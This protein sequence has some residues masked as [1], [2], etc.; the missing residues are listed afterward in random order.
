[1]LIT[2]KTVYIV[3][4]SL[5]LFFLIS[6]FI[7][8]IRKQSE[9]FKTI[10]GI[11]FST[12]LML[13]FGI[14]AVNVQNERLAS[15]FYSLLYSVLII[16]NIVILRLITILEGVPEEVK[17]HKFIRYI[18]YLFVLVDAVFIS[19]K[20]ECF[21][22]ISPSFIGDTFYV[23]NIEYKHPFIVHQVIGFSFSIHI[24]IKL[25]KNISKNHLFYRKRFTIFLIL[26]VF[27]QICNV[28]YIT[29]VSFFKLD[30]TPLI[31]GIISIYA[32]FF[33]AFTIPRTIKDNMLSIASETIS[34][35]VICFDNKGNCLYCN[36]SA[37][38]IYK[39]GESQWIN[40]YLD[41]PKDEIKCEEKIDIDGDT[42]TFNV[43]FKKI[44]DLSGKYSGAYIKLNDMTIELNEIKLEEY[45]AT[46]DEL[47]G[48]ANRAAFFN[49]CE[50]VIRQNPDVP[51]YLVATNIK[52][53]K[54]IN[55]LFGTKF[56][57]NI[58]KRQADMLD[59]ANYTNCVK[60]RV[61]GD[62]F[63]M[64]IP[65]KSF[66]IDLAVQNT[67]F[68]REL[69][70]NVRFPLTIQIG[71]YEIT[72][73]TEKVYTM[74]NKAL[75]ALKNNKDGVNGP[76]LV[77]FYDTSLMNR[78][79]YEQNIIGEFRY[80]LKNNDF[81]VFIQAQVDSATDTCKGG[82]AL[83]R[84]YDPKALYRQPGDFIEILES[85][86]L[87]YKLD[88]YVWESAAKILSKWKKAGHEDFYISVNISAKDFYYNDLYQVFTKLV[89]QYDISPANYNLELTESA[90][91]DKN[92]P[93]KNVLQRLREYGFRIEMD[94][95]G[96]GYSS[97][98]VLKE[99]K[100]DVLK[101][102]MEFLHKSENEDR[103][104]SIIL[105]IVNMAKAL[106]M[107]VIAEGVE[108]NEQKDF[109]KELG[110][111]TF[112]GYL[113]SKPIEVSEFEEKYMGGTI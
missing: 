82:E 110:V 107:K 54:F 59:K 7:E 108:T 35:A 51:R 1:M 50:K 3:I 78:I 28:I 91:I 52:N 26:Y 111:D 65:K 24:L 70:Q 53:F 92:T 80:A 37:K 13:V 109:L 43:E 67:N 71:V 8:S 77:S 113:F 30:F 101:I 74:Y 112:Q 20:P 100:M 45:R 86:G 19:V 12:I 60:G 38:M 97:L 56:G 16:T 84:W 89:E 46:H 17:S 2:L 9:L 87:I 63:A 98:N 29:N 25:I 4:C 94:D 14:Y 58:I 10:A 88:Y 99:I 34:D 11:Q 83:V 76:N 75:L 32:F 90:V 69:G 57:D 55:D 6:C 105:S 73:P 64:L 42:H 27:E 31:F 23:W 49:K 72:D 22:N 68:V 61:S 102:D 66:N 48:L 106:E 41:S 95:F 47:T 103:G 44:R 62:K 104:R 96:S 21:F 85:N 79:L 18:S 33:A 93:H 36:N 40:K 81:H 15:L 5:I 39:P